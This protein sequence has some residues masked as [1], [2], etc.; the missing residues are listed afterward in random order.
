MN[1]RPPIR[2]AFFVL[3]LSLAWSSVGRADEESKRMCASAF[4]SGQRLMRA[5][6]LLEARNK[7]VLCGGPQCPEAMHPDC[8]QWLST[9]E[10]SLPTVVFQ[11]LATSG[12]PSV[13]GV[14][15]SV[16]GQDGVALD[17]RAMSMDPGAHEVTF[18]APGFQPAT[19]H[20]VV[21]E[22]EKLRREV[23]T[24]SPVPVVRA[25]IPSPPPELGKAACDQCAE[26]KQRRLTAPA[27]V[28]ASLSL[29][30]GA[31]AIYF[32]V[33]A[34]NDD[35]ALDGCAPSSSCSKTA[36]DQVRSEYLWTNVSIGVAAAGITTAVV[37]YLLSAKSADKPQQTAFG[38]GAFPNGLASTLTRRF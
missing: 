3:G 22:G 37:L 1:G 38:I 26:P 32:G 14:Q 33:K 25:P 31:G 4:T 30:A 21:S 13:E 7:L 18:V 27:I 16:D 12:A 2:V 19:K 23:V 10:A 35:H 11:V 24:L 9:V 17:G 34:R 36:V 6:R 29:V 15:L 5:G 20:I 8:Q 28:A